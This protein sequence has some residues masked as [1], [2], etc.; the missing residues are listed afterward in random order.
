MNW[1]ARWVCLP[2]ALALGACGATADDPA[3]ASGGG[4][5]VV[6]V[7]SVGGISGALYADL[8]VS[9][10][11]VYAC[12][13]TDGMRVADIGDSGELTVTQAQ[14]TFAEGAGCRS[15]A[16]AS[17]GAVLVGGEAASGGS[18]IGQ[19]TADGA[20]LEGSITL[21]TGLIETVAANQTHAYVALGDAGLA[22]L[23]RNDGQLAQVGS[24]TAGLD[25]AL[26]VAIASQQRL[27]VANGLSGAAIVDI[28][29]PTTPTIERTIKTPGTARRVAV[30]GGVIW[31]ADV[32]AGVSTFHLDTGAA[33]G[34]W[35]T[36]GSAVDLAIDS[37]G[38]VLVANLEDVS[39]LDGSTTGDP[40]LVA[41]EVV[42]K[43]DDYAGPPRVV[44]VRP[45]SG[46]AV[47]AEWSGLWTLSYDASA[48][49]PDIHLSRTAV[50]LGLVSLKKGQA[51]IVQNL[52]RALLEISSVSVD[53]GDFAFDLERD[54]L[55][56]GQK[57]V[58]EV[59]F[60]P[61]DD[62]PVYATL[63]LRTNDPD[64]PQVEIPLSANSPTTV[65][66]GEPFDAPSPRMFMHYETGNDVSVASV[67][68]G[69][70][71]ILA[72]FGTT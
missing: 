45:W 2:L 10:G 65:G 59:T 16:V 61:S 29:D 11:R 57:T 69:K 19:V 43:S 39:I 63:T 60:E 26:G 62:Q 15:V 35:E 4:D 27:V 18:W 48:S 40:A 38:R 3:A 12:T 31:V 49:V 21:A 24:L 9:G 66:V 7:A 71:V 14:V 70:V 20:A 5:N 46:L 34:R 44:A 8:A 32:S 54:R 56:P 13:V 68:S 23:G 64:E 42:G 30:S 47:A 22:A 41:T 28:S 1:R 52:G 37:L 36:H 50:A 55:A 6:P 51:I 53:H 58:L 17:D 33:I 67:H 25:R 72:W